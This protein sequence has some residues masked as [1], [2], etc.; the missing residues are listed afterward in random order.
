MPNCC[1]RA[2]SRCGCG[3][4]TLE[5]GT[6]MLQAAKSANATSCVVTICHRKGWLELRDLT[7][8][9]SSRMRVYGV[10]KG[11][12]ARRSDNPH[13]T[14]TALFPQEQVQQAASRWDSNNN[15]KKCRCLFTYSDQQ[16]A[17]FV[18]CALCL[19]V[20]AGLHQP[21]ARGGRFAEPCIL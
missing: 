18:R 19:M 13:I 16:D 8:V 20:N 3:S 2:V 4:K 12:F 5:R 6:G 17:C 9:R 7:L 11:K 21:N 10:P 1:P 14:F 15:H